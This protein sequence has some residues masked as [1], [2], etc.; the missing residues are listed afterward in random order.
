MKIGIVSDT[1]NNLRN[2]GRI[3]ELFNES[4]VDRVIHT[5]DITQAKTIDVLA[6]LH[7]PVHGVFGNNDQ[8]RDTLEYAMTKHGFDFREPPY[9]LTLAEREINVDEL[10]TFCEDAPMSGGML[11]K[12]TATLRC[13]PAI[14]LDDLQSVL[15]GL[16]NDIMVAIGVADA[17]E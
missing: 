7:M 16:A 14:A 1:H 6:N 12:A 8:E 5:G 13:P 10:Y 4:G 9:T 3:V 11:F 15:E 2:V 17:D